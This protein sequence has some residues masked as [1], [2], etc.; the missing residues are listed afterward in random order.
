M[1]FL[2]VIASLAAGCRPIAGDPLA[3]T[4]S[5]D[6][7][8][9]G[10][11]GAYL[12]VRDAA[13]RV[14]VV[15]AR[16]PGLLCR[17]STASGAGLAP[18]V[19][20]RAGRVTVGLVATGGDGPDEVLVE[21]NRDVR[22]D[23][24]MPAGAGEQELDLRGARVTR[25][26]VGPS[27]LVSLRLPR[28]RGTLPVTLLSAGTVSLEAAGAAPM[29]LRLAEGARSVVPPGAVGEPREWR[30]ARDRY[31]VLARSEVGALTLRFS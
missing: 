8:L 14:R 22:W 19:R 3:I 29:R 24:R 12:L 1:A 4:H 13:S 2:L 11:T 23:I 30:T 27:G 5:E 15:T 6:I 28:P 25:V 10:R 9:S 7:A 18:S 16:L 17:V 21:L 31:A 20:E 26:E